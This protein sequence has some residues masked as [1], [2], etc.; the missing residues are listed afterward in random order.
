LK[1]I[2][3]KNFK[4]SHKKDSQKV[5]VLAKFYFSLVGQNEEK[6][7]ERKTFTYQKFQGWETNSKMEKI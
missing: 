4:V 6:L 1:S 2:S 7:K 3:E 5:E